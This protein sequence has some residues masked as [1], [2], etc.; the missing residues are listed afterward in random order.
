MHVTHTLEITAIC[1]V[2]DKADVYEC[3]VIARRV[4]AIED[5]LKAVEDVKTMKAYQETICQELHRRLACEVRLVGYH[6]GVLTD[7]VCGERVGKL[8][9]VIRE[10]L[11]HNG[12]GRI[13]G[14][15]YE[16][17]GEEKPSMHKLKGGST[18]GGS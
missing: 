16:A 8:E 10:Y 7:V 15:A 6:S 5:I 9:S 2:D 1:P 14:M 18:E 3:I 12:D 17:L 4:I 11:K 13:A